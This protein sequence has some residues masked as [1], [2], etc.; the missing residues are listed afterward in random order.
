MQ[1]LDDDV[2]LKKD[3]V[4]DQLEKGGY[5]GKPLGAV[6]PG[7]GQGCADVPGLRLCDP[8]A[9]VDPSDVMQGLPPVAVYNYT[10][11]R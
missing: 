2:T 8:G 7:R 3:A 6:L 11:T 1:V 5:I 4:S 9:D 10:L